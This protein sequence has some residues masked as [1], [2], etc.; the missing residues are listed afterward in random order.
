MP[1]YNVYHR[2]LEYNYSSNE[3]IEAS[4]V[5]AAAEKGFELADEKGLDIVESEVLEHVIIV[6]DENDIVHQYGDGSS[7][8]EMPELNTNRIEA[9]IY[10]FVDKHYGDA[11]DPCYNLTEMAKHIAE[12]YS[13]NWESTIPVKY[14]WDEEEGEENE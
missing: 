1:K 7:Y 8:E 11:N 6:E 13:S 10:E 3:I 14:D 4:S 9:I 5:G 2:F 12:K